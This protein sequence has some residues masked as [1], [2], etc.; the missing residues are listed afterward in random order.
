MEGRFVTPRA[1]VRATLADTP[2]RYCAGKDTKKTVTWA[3]W[4][5][6]CQEIMSDPRHWGPYGQRWGTGAHFPLVV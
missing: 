5:R 2:Y 3:S 6:K 1:A 4:P